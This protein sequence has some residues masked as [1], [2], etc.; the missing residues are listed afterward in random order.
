MDRLL[1]VTDIQG[2]A[3]EELNADAECVEPGCFR[4]CERD[5]RDGTFSREVSMGNADVYVYCSCEHHD[6]K[7]G[8]AEAGIQWVRAGK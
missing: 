1:T 4:S 2:P 3:P 6:P 5:S 7:S 8:F